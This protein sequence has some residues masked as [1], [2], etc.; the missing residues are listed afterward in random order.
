LQDTWPARDGLT[1]NV[2]V[3]YDGESGYRR[4]N[5]VPDDHNNVQPRIGFVWA[6][7]RDTRTAIR[8]GYGLYVDRSFLNV[9][10]DVAAAQNSDT[11]VIQNPGYPDPFS[12][13]TLGTVTPSKT[14]IAQHPQSPQTQSVSLG[15]QRE[16]RSGLSVSADGVY[17]RG[18][19]QFNNRDLN[20]PLFPGGPRPDPTIGRIIQFGMEGNSWSTALLSSIQYR[21]QRG[22]AFGVSYTLSR[23]LRDVEDFQYFAQDELHPELDKAPAAND[24]THQLVVNFNWNLP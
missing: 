12:R 21:P 22:P 15:F 5:G 9:Q 14:V 13:G 4:I 6:P 7:F 11:I 2:G 18:K 16:I 17:S 19:Y 3:R 10:L 8:G 24:R 20:H 23:S 1:L